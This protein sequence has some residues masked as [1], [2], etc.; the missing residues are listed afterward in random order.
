MRH[1]R[2]GALLQE[3]LLAP[4]F[5]IFNPRNHARSASSK[6]GTDSDSIYKEIDVEDVGAMIPCGWLAVVDS[7]PTPNA[8][9]PMQLWNQSIPKPRNQARSA[10]SGGGTD[11]NPICKEIDV[12]DA[13]SQHHVPK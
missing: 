4:R 12:E 6:G 9:L 2:G 1:C 5:S 3:V 7:A 13:G 8:T 11:S 10:S